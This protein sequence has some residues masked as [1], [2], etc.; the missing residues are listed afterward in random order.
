MKTRKK[1]VSNSSSSSFIIAFDKKPETE[2]EVKKLLFVDDEMSIEY[3]DYKAD[4]G[5]IAKQVFHDIKDQLPAN[6]FEV[7]EEISHGWIDGH[8]E[9]QDYITE[10][11]D[12]NGKNEKYREQ[13]KQWDKASKKFN[14]KKA[15]ELIKEFEGKELF[16]VE[17]ADRDGNF[18]CVMEHGDIFENIPHFRISKH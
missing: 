5:D 12:S 18:G 9:Y 11:W 14:R 10:K 3:F 8:P 1:F 13:E 4:V 7:E 16:V 2:E 6:I 17:Y 15:K